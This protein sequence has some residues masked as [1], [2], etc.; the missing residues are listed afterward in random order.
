[1]KTMINVIQK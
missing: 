1:M